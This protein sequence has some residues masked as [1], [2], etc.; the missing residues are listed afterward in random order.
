[1]KWW[2]WALAAA[3]AIACLALLISRVTFAEVSDVFHKI[4][5]WE[6]VAGFGVVLVSYLLKAL[7]FRILLGKGAGF[8]KLFGVT[9]A[10]NII[11]QLIPARAGDVSYIVMVRKAGMASVGYG[12]ASLVLCRVVDLV[13]LVGMYVWSLSVLDLHVAAFRTVA[14]VVGAFVLVA[15]LCVLALI[16][17]GS[18]AVAM[19][20]CLLEKTRLLRLKW[21]KYLWDEMVDAF[22]HLKE[23]RLVRHVL[24]ML[25]VS[26]L[27]WIATAGW[28]YLIW[29][30]VGVS[31][32]VPELL[33]IFSLAN[34]LGLFP[35][36][37]FGGVGTMD[38]VN[39]LVLVSFG[40]AV[41]QAASFTL[42]NRVLGALYQV[43]LVLLVLAVLGRHLGRAKSDETGT[44]SGAD[45]G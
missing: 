34:I 35:L 33:F 6:A 9:V 45:R 28:V 43:G 18:G 23:L 37:F 36:F 27:V 12:L 22:P 21:V 2:K 19:A 17:F 20:Q 39:A 26:V 29:G 31:L 25:G 13:I 15:V 42:C 3:V 32:S 5:I 14:Y 10:Q 16:V 7:R 1:M 11:A 38:A 40:R 44:E 8:G 30:A 4:R 24:P 41:V